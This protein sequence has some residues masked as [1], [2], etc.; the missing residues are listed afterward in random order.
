MRSDGD[1]YTT[2]G[3]VQDFAVILEN[4]DNFSVTLE[5]NDNVYKQQ[6]I[7]RIFD[8]DNATVTAEEG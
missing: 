4:Y 3:D 6:E 2:A 5:D 8:D 1:G 7:F